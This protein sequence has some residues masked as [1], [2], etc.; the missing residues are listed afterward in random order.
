[1]RITVRVAM[2]C[3]VVLT[4]LGLG[5]GAWLS[6][7]VEAPAAS[8]PGP[9][10]RAPQV[11]GPRHRP[12]HERGQHRERPDH[13]SGPK[14]PA[15]P[16][17]IVLVLMDDVSMDLVQTMSQ[18]AA[19]RRE[20]ASFEH[21]FVVDSL[22]CVSR[23][24]LLTGQYP[25]Q[26]GVRTNTANTPN[27]VGPVGGWE[28]FA[29]YGN[30]E[31]SVNV[32]LQQAGYTTGFVGK[33]LNQYEPVPDP[34][35]PPGWSDWE[36][37]FGNAYDGWDFDMTQPVGDDVV[38]RH[39]DA[40]PAAASEEEKDAAYA[41]TV[42]AD[43]ALAFIRE[44]R[45]DD[46]PYFLA[47]APYAA[48]SRVGPHPYYPGDP[49]F[50]PA[51]RDRPGPG[52]P[53]NCGPVPCGDLGLDDLPGFGDDQA[54]NAP[55]RADGSP[56]PRW[57]LHEPWMTPGVALSNLRSRAQ[58]VQS[59]DRMLRRIRAAVGP[60]TYVVLTSDNG[61]HLGQHGLD[62]GKGTPFVSDVQVP[63]LVTGPGVVPG[64]R[65]EVV[66]NLDL[67]ATFEQLAG[68]RRAPYR[69]GSSLVPTFG[70]PAT[71]HRRF[72][73][74]E[75]TWARSLGTDPDAM[76]AGGTMD[77][78]PSYVAVRSR[79]GLLVRFDL[80]PDWEGLD[81]AWEYY[82]YT[83]TG[84]ER[85]NQY[86]DPA[87]RSEIALLTRR[88]ARFDHCTATTGDDPVPRQCRGLTR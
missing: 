9:G 14:G 10:S 65:Q 43:R 32:R 18:A 6:P 71:D 27:P 88:L 61:F 2:A 50:P 7:K 80:D 12:G 60:D 62:R 3:A 37:V 31:R 28:A 35:V 33:Y 47:V 5:S 68:L 73:F 52:R 59:V 19:M 42:I 8:S 23:S 51:F 16:S 48:H 84:W 46:A 38:V 83:D 49:G 26:T 30:P 57:R 75:H 29:A 64:R 81:P 4:A 20:G 67:A 40:P 17:N 85:T 87:H 25:H 56:A 41:G 45:R 77:L 79:T 13:P 76:Y 1:M 15:S 34:V 21:S 54:D 55:R 22:C 82:D 78:I 44:H 53:G 74:F 72:T 69:S 70:D 24:S 58:M 63:L 39:V 36:A 66:S 11:P 86:G